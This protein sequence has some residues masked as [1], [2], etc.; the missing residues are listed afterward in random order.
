MRKLLFA[1]LCIASA[2]SITAQTL[3]SYGN[4]S[5]SKQ[6]FLRAYN[7]NKT[8][9]TDKAKALKE[10]LDLYVKFKLK[11]QAAKDLRYDTL[12]GLVSDLENFRAQIQE[13]YMNDE[14]EM[15]RLVYEAF[16]RSQKDVH[17]G[18]LFFPI[19]KN[20]D[21]LK[22]VNAAKKVADMKIAD[23]SGQV[24]KLKGQSITSNY[25]DAGYITVFTLPYPMENVVYGL[26]QGQISQPYKTKSGYY[27]FQNLGERPAV[28][29]IRAAQILI[30][31][32]E[33][34]ANAEK[35]KAKKLADSLYELV[36]KGDDFGELAARFSNDKATSMNAGIMDEFGT[37]KYEPSYEQQVF[38]LKKDGDVTRPFLTE[39]GYH[40][41]K[42]VNRTPVSNDRTNSNVLLDLKQKVIADKRGDL[43]KAKFMKE[44]LRLTGYKPATVNSKD[45]WRVTDSFLISKKKITAGSVNEKTVLFTFRK[46]N[47]KVSDWLD[48]VKNYKTVSNNTEAYK[49][50]MDKFISRTASNYYRNHLE[51]LN[52]DFKFQVQEFKEGNMLFEI[53]EKNV[54][55]KAASDTAALLKY[56]NE[57]KDKYKWGKS[58]DAVVL[59]CTNGETGN[60][61]FKYVMEG[62]NMQ[63][64]KTVLGDAV[65]GDSS[66]M[67][68]AQLP[69]KEKDIQQGKAYKVANTSNDGAVSVVKI[70]NLYP[71]GET[72][73]YE[74]AKGLVLNDYQNYLE[75]QWVEQIKKKYPVKVNE[76]VFQSIK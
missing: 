45:L 16:D 4:N 70:I 22:A 35:E 72:R 25:S 15:N 9:T 6:E 27:I 37:G 26:K 8:T 7:K 33:G 3:F 32:P 55:S 29:K 41:V 57:H 74:E 56:Y 1:L 28:G 71:A 58:A 47:I 75:D 50:I 38:A 42:Q 17:I 20:N 52:A 66:R 34:A 59:N 39:F 36:K 69:L 18:Y 53:M 73:S 23:L 2:Q 65:Q 19:D 51:E 13:A 40:I 10:Y 12:P 76:A 49:D 54:W 14:T 63:E 64:I 46:S 11:V 21:S 48:F 43:A 62:Q 24:E 67:E 44:I 5:V 60:K 68:Y 61:V 30:A 31:I